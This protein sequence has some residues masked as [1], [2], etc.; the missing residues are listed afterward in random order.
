MF[1]GLVLSGALL[2]ACGGGGSSS[3][4][5]PAPAATPAISATPA[6]SGAQIVSISDAT[7]G[8]AIYYTLDNTPPTTSSQI[9]Q[10]PFLVASSI[11]VQAVATASGYTTSGVTSRQ[12]NPNIASGT[13][14]WSDE[15]DTQGQPNPL[16]SGPMTPAAAAS[17]TTSRRPIAPGDRTSVLVPAPAPAPTR[18][19]MASCTSW[20]KSR[21][22][23]CTLPLASRA[24]A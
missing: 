9:Y 8:A 3:G 22:R 1:A 4:S 13:L 2:C 21:P 5:G 19:P 20:L 6:Q 15:F 12:F 24:R 17:A 23:A 16:R 18:A 11:A 14:V 7:A 10:A